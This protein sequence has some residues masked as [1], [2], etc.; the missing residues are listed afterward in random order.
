MHINH[1]GPYWLGEPP[2]AELVMHSLH[3]CATQYFQL[4]A[5]CIM[6]NHVHV[7]LKHNLDA[8]PMS[9]I[10]Q[11]HKGFTGQAANKLLGRT[12]KFWQ[13]ETYDHVVRNP[14]EFDRIVRYILN[15]PVKA[16]LVKR[17]EDWPYS[18]V[19]P[20]LVINRNT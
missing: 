3:F 20:T 15:N 1:N 5:F 13:R 6:S 18:Y 7:L 12:G 16:K 14:K 8:Q 4:W 19:H 9:K 17:W 2:I 10:L 11:S